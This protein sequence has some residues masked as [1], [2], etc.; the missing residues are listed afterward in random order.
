MP[1]CPAKVGR[2]R[3]TKSDELATLEGFTPPSTSRSLIN[4]AASN[5]LKRLAFDST[6]FDITATKAVSFLIPLASMS[7]AATLTLNGIRIKTGD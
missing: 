7:L 2:R 6:W 4:Q 5:L 1:H 3:N